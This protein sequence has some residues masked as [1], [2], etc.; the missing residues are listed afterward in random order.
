M[1]ALLLL[2]TV[3]GIPLALLLPLLYALAAFVG[4][5]ASAYLLGCKLLRLPLDAKGPMFAPIAAGT[6]FVT[7]FYL[8][9]VPL[10]AFEGGFRMFG[11][12]LLAL[13][14]VV[15][16][17][18]WMLGFGALLLVAPRPGRQREGGVR[19]GVSVARL[20]AAESAD[21]VAPASITS[22]G[23][24]FP[25]RPRGLGEL[26]RF[27]GRFMGERTAFGSLACSDT[28]LNPCR[29]DRYDRSCAGAPHPARRR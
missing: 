21:D 26:P 15:G 17:V 7:L 12:T 10:I 9:G 29:F 18:C 2:V 24:S 1:L 14:I 28:P 19:R 4:Y 16:K 13:W 8:L 20:S 6:G 3:I 5:V 23:R 22:A 25:A 11:F 27:R